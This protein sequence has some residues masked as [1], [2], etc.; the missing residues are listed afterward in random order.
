MRVLI[1]VLALA[2]AGAGCS[3]NDSSLSTSVP[4]PSGSPSSLGSVPSPSG[5][6]SSLGSVPSPSGSPSS[7][8][9]VPSPSG[10]PSS[11]GSEP[12]SATP[13]VESR[14]EPTPTVVKQW[15]VDWEDL[16]GL[17][18][19]MGDE[20][21][22]LE[23]GRATVTHGG[24]SADHYTLQNRVAQGDLNG[25]G[26]DDVVAHIVMASAGSGTFHLLV[27]VIDDGIGGEARPPV[28]VGDRI[29]M[30]G[31]A[32]RDGKVEVALFDREPDEPF[33]VISQYRTLEID[34][35]GPEPAVSVTDSQ[36]LE[37]LPFPEPELP[38]IEIRFDPAEVGA[39]VAGS[40]EFRRRQTYSA[41]ISAGQ[42]F[43]AT[44][45]APVGVWLD[46][47][48]GDR[49]VASASDRSQQVQAELPVT[50]PWRVSVVSAHAGTTD[51]K[52][53]IEA[54]PVR[55]GSGEDPTPL[56]PGGDPAS[57]D[58]DPTPPASA[59]EDPVSPGTD[60]TPPA[61]AGE[62]P[63]SPDT[64]PGP[65]AGEAAPVMY[66]T[67][68]D[69]PHPVYTPQVLDVL[70]RYDVTATFFVLG[71]LAET[72]PAIIQRI[73]DEGHA[74]GNHTWNHESLAGLP[75]EKFD[76]TVGRTQ[77]LLG[78]RGS[79]CL[80]PPYGSMDALTRDWAGEHG[81]NVALWN[82][83]PKDWQRPPAL[84]IA[85]HIV[86]H[87][88]DGAIILLHDGGDDRSQTVLGLDAALSDL[89]R[90]G[91]DFEPLCG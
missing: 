25:D 45:D 47:R 18:F 76:D 54:L 71:S 12:A 8:G 53:A 90:R 21:I 6:P 68:D 43:T 16:Q 89:S 27:P 85:Q 83:D 49:V 32:V 52:L 74:I 77:A 36:P 19:E 56:V 39:I 29:V 23:E 28:P 55:T 86:D 58:T 84:S 41:H 78:N 35:S 91:F 1:V 48:L 82:V 37:N 22:R 31:F 80:R 2:M 66:F 88:R 73:L 64:D 5:S 17:S 9:S 20:T 50:G 51:Y 61:S 26:F 87:A 7:L 10:S 63:V 40:I 81:L 72:Y 69:G 13:G 44:L 75:R 65:S 24:A 34:L 59:E 70:A 67:F 38:E 30:D 14:P 62:G 46:V 57:S 42:L 33:T 60:P 79:P 15:G 3:G 4:S 11:L